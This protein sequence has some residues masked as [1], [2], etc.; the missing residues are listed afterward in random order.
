MKISFTR[1]NA[2]IT[3]AFSSA[4]VMFVV[5]NRS[6]GRNMNQFIEIVHLFMRGACPVSQYENSNHMN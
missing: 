2:M 1:M 3:R 4:K 5:E 6:D